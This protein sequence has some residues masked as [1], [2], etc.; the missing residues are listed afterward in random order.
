MYSDLLHQLA[1]MP[2]A[3]AP[4]QL[5][6]EQG[7]HVDCRLGL[8]ENPFSLHASLLKKLSGSLDQLGYYGDPHSFDLRCSLAGV[9]GISPDSIAVDPG[10]D[11][12]LMG[13][14]DLLLNPGD[15]IVMMDGTHPMC[16]RYSVM[17]RADIQLVHYEQGKVPIQQFLNTVEQTAPKVVY[18]ANPDNPSGTFFDRGQLIEIIEEVTRHSLFILDEAYLD[19]VS[20]DSRLPYDYQNEK[21]IRLR[22]FS[23]LYGLAGLRVGYAVAIP[24]IIQQYE[25]IRTHFGV[26]R[27][28]Q[29][30]A[31]ICLN[32]KSLAV[33]ML[34][35]HE[36]SKQQFIGQLS[37]FDAS[38]IDCPA[39]FVLI[40]FGSE[41]RRDAVHENLLRQ[42]VSTLAMK[43]PGMLSYLRVSVG[44]E[45]CMNCCAKLILDC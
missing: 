5:T 23:K 45:E 20:P 4:E 19:Y 12:I 36:K 38:V 28:A 18:L 37:A 6:R 27:L 13:L 2:L 21:L 17:C 7:V 32:D 42:G 30:F 15:R 1:S 35:Q 22:T 14:C 9:Y 29:A 26:N 41:R 25:K 31:N 33:D 11:A 43:A 40:D 39:N 10:I 3:K 16:R 34:N 44:G 8:N 24:D